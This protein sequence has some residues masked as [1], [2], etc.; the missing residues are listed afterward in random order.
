MK[1][2]IESVI[3]KTTLPVLFSDN[4]EE[5]CV[6]HK[7]A[8]RSRAKH[9]DIKVYFLREHIRPGEM[10]LKYPTATIMVA[11]VLKKGLPLIRLAQIC[12]ILFGSAF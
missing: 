12:K 7:T 1:H 2:V 4:Q 11:D 9:I 3:Y 6:A 5:I 10:T 8:S